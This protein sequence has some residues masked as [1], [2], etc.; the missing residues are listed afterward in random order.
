MIPL[1]PFAAGLL[2]GITA[3]KLAKNDKTKAS[4]DKAQEKIREA[5]VSGL[6]A[7]ERSSAK[8]R[9]KMEEKPT[10]A[11]PPENTATTEPAPVPPAETVANATE[12]NDTP[13]Q[14]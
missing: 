10:E 3:V 8:L 1:L 11:P 14:P 4:L 13:A 9:T 12:P 7:I 6:T 5:T 2:V